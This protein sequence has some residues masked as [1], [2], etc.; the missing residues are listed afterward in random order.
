[1]RRLA[2]ASGLATIALLTIP[3]G[4]SSSS[5]GAGAD[6]G[7]GDS[8]QSGDTSVGGDSG[9]GGDSGGDGG[10]QVTAD[11]AC[12]DYARAVCTQIGTCAPFYVTIAFGDAATC[13]T[14]LKLSCAA[15][16]AAPTTS[17]TPGSMETCV[18]AAAG[19]S[20][21]DLLGNNPPAACQPQ[22]G[23]LADGSPCIDGSQCM[24]HACHKPASS[25]CG[26]C[27]SKA[28]AGGTCTSNDDC[29]L[30]VICVKANGAS[31][32]TCQQAGGMGATCNATQ[33]CNPTLV[34]KAGACAPPD[35]L[36]QSC[37]SMPA[38]TC[39]LLHGDFCAPMDGGSTCVMVGA[40]GSGQTCGFFG[41]SFTI[42]SANGTCVTEGGPSGL[43]EPTLADGASCS[44]T[45]GAQ[46]QQ[47]AECQSGTCTLPDAANCH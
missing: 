8:S 23:S 31:T 6:G 16:L 41:G 26:T 11:Q 9:T 20:C 18:Q 47:P 13:E 43:C 30:S 36:G 42:C 5:A 27:G 14:R 40:A 17:W 32:G 33:A 34:C 25:T 2:L 39:D 21:S 29:A 1:M 10:N 7:G 37:S 35:A 3:G 46:C 4:C 45:S 12:T 28:A 44:T 15:V 19:A 24:N 22:A 38:S